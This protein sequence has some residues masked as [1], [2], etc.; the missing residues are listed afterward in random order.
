MTF[1]GTWPTNR[2]YRD[3][4]DGEL[5][6]DDD[7]HIPRHGTDN[8]A[9]F[10]FFNL[11]KV[12]NETPTILTSTSHKK[13]FTAS[14]SKYLLDKLSPNP[15]CNRLLCPACLANNINNVYTYSFFTK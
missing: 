5:R 10:P 13:V 7:F 15:N 1:L 3:I 12:R 8:I 11:P 14:V 6:N 9:R 2:D 4:G